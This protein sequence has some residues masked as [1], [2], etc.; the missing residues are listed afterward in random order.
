MVSFPFYLSF[1]LFSLLELKIPKVPYL[2]G[3]TTQMPQC[4]YYILKIFLA[5]KCVQYNLYNLTIKGTTYIIGT[6]KLIKCFY[7]Y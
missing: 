4:E 1:A 7:K 2:D 6:G 3:K 5:I